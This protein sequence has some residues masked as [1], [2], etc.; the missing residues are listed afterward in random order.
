MAYTCEST[1]EELSHLPK[2]LRRCRRA[3]Y[4]HL[5]DEPS[6]FL[7]SY[8][9][10]KFVRY[11]HKDHIRDPNP[12]I[13]RYERHGWVK[14]PDGIFRNIVCDAPQDPHSLF[15]HCSSP[16]ARVDKYFRAFT[17]ADSK[18][19]VGDE[20]L[21]DYGGTDVDKYFAVQLNPYQ[22]KS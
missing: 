12:N 6:Q 5:Q 17:D 16:N 4:K 13:W 7:G 8:W 21:I 1:R 22:K 2:E 15:N 3:K 18:I 20:L 19:S 9:N 11:Y 14:F 10:L